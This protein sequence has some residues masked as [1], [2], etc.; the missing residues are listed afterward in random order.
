M[1]VCSDHRRHA[2]VEPSG[3]RH[4][5]TRRLGMDV[6]QDDGSRGPGFVH[7]RVDELPH[8]SGGLE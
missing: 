2:T 6:D 5:L 8:A 7:E 3:E 4:L 1:R